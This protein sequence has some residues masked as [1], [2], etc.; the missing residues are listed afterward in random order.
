MNGFEKQIKELVSTKQKYRNK[1]RF[2]SDEKEIQELKNKAKE[3]T[4]KID[5]LRKWISYCEGIEE[6]SLQITKF[7]EEKEN[8]KSRKDKL[9][10]RNEIYRK[11][12][13]YYILI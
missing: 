5:S 3:L 9:Y 13:E 6:H 12:M 8:T 11:L 7:V 10:E 2:F 4:P 1:I